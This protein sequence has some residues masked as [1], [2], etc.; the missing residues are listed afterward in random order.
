VATTANFLQYSFILAQ[1]EQEQGLH[2][3]HKHCVIKF[4]LDDTQGQININP[5][6]TSPSS[7]LCNLKDCWYIVGGKYGGN[8]EG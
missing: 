3:S 5:S 6:A 1:A 4:E 7:V 2:T 8:V